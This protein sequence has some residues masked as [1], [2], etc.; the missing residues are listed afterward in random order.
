M[1][2]E[3]KKQSEIEWTVDEIW[4]QYKAHTLEL[5]TTARQLGFAAIAICWTIK[6]NSLYL[7]P[8]LQATLFLAVLF[9][10]F[11]LSHYICGAYCNHKWAK[12][13]QAKKKKNSEY[14]C[15]KKLNEGRWT[16]KFFIIKI[17]T[18]F[19]TYIVLSIYFVKTYIN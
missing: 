8:I 7:P 13:C 11:D 18:I 12:R 4:A 15:K 2:N 9:F 1:S 14:V 10:I 5:S 3:Q 16:K 6:P 17:L 19:F